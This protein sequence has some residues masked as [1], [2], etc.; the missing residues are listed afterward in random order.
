MVW[1]SSGGRPGEQ[2]NLRHH[3]H[4]TLNRR[5]SICADT[6]TEVPSRRPEAIGRSPQVSHQSSIR[7]RYATH[8]VNAE[9]LEGSSVGSGGRW[10]QEKLPAVV[11]PYKAGSNPVA[12]AT[13]PHGI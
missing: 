10:Q 5:S 1:A 13:I 6:L 3:R 8:L 9:W 11:P 2:D 12:V 7:S 4:G